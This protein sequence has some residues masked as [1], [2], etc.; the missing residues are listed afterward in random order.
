MDLDLDRYRQEHAGEPHKVTLG[1]KTY[2]LP[3]TLPVIVPDLLKRGEI[4]SALECLF[5]DD[6]MTVGKQLGIDAEGGDF[7]AI[8]SLYGVDLPEPSASP[9]SSVSSGVPSRL[10][11]NGSTGVTS[12]PLA[13]VK[14][15]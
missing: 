7:L 4:I 15:K 14:T 6:A 8:F 9:D 2:L 10:T 12:E 1:G 5:G 13:S 11:S 3:A